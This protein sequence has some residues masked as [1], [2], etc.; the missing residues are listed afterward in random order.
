[1]SKTT[2]QLIKEARKNAKV[3]QKELAER[4]GIAESTLSKWKKRD[5]Q[6]KV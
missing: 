5:E 2:G 6:S 4:L 1:M 3:T